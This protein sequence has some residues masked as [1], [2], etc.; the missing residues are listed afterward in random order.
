MPRIALLSVALLMIGEVRAGRAAEPAGEM[1]IYAALRPA[2]WD[3]YLFDKPGSEPR[4]L[5]TD[6]GPDYDGVFSPDGRWLVFCSERRG[7]PDLYVLD[8]H[9]PGPPRPLTSGDAMEDAAAF[10]PDGR[11]LAFVS[12]RDGSADIFVMPFSSDWQEAA[13]ATNLT[14][15]SGGDFSPAFSPDGQWIAFSSDRDGYKASEIYVMRSDGSETR[16]LT[17]ADGWDGAP[18]WSADGKAIYFY[19]QRDAGH[20]IYRMAQDGSDPR[21]VTPAGEAAVSPVLAPGG[22]L[23]Y[24]SRRNERSSIASVA[25]DGSGPRLESDSTRDYWAPAY[26]A[27]SGRMVCHGP[28]PAGDRPVFNSSTPGPFVVDD[29][30]QVK[31]PDRQL[32]VRAIRGYFPSL[33]P[34]GGRVASDEGF[35]RIVVS[36]LDGTGL[37]E[38]YGP[39]SGTAWRPTWSKDGR[40]IAATVGPTFA[41]PNA[42]AD[43]WKFMPDGSQAVNLTAD[44]PANDAFPDF[45][46]DGG[47]IVFRSG[48]EGNHDIYLMDADGSNVRRLTDHAATDTMPAFA[49]DGKRVAF[50]SNRDDD[51]EIYILSLDV[52]QRDTDGGQDR[53]RRITNS[54]GRDTHPCFSPDGKWL[55][56]ASERGGMNDEVPLI[57]IFN[58]QPYGEIFAIRLEDGKLVRLTHNKWED[59][60]PT[61]GRLPG[62]GF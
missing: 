38:A 33:G 35:D 12:T 46:P 26:D 2:N 9:N 43:I 1:V 40:W 30:H 41:A 52:A 59:G 57:P 3:L 49:P 4:R 42:R 16:R 17:Q 13:D 25:L 15:R 55:V 32:V 6:A 47:R 10:S 48:R 22:R 37:H 44:S 60:T 36:R 39:A 28:G 58:P 53:P 14:R 45:S 7:N 61:W 54:P 62:T 8:L 19:S 34:T 50:T 24:A 56:F 23:A 18:V 5:T 31:L 20:R 29:R 11:S 27:K 51:Y 21:P